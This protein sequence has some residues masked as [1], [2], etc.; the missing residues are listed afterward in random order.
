MNTTNIRV[1]RLVGPELAP[2][3]VGKPAKYL[4]VADLSTD[5]QLES[6]SQGGFVPNP[7]L[8]VLAQTAEARTYKFEE[9]SRNT[10]SFHDPLM[11]QLAVCGLLQTDGK[12]FGGS[13]RFAADVDGD[14]ASAISASAAAFPAAP[15]CFSQVAAATMAKDG[16]WPPKE[17]SGIETTSLSL[18]VGTVEVAIRNEG[19]DR[20]IWDYW[21]IGSKKLINGEHYL[22]ILGGAVY[23]KVVHGAFP[24]VVDQSITSKPKLKTYKDSAAVDRIVLTLTAGGVEFDALIDDPFGTAAQI[25]VRLRIAPDGA[26]EQHMVLLQERSGDKGLR[27]VL[28]DL[29]EAVRREQLPLV[30]DIRPGPA[31]LVW[32]LSR[33]EHRLTL[34]DGIKRPMIAPGALRATLVTEPV[35]GARLNTT[36]T[37]IK[38]GLMIDSTKPGAR[39]LVVEAGKQPSES[40]AVAAV[41]LVKLRGKNAFQVGFGGRKGTA[42]ATALPVLVERDRLAAELELRYQRQGLSPLDKPV[43][44]FA[45]VALERGV[46]QIPLPKIQAP[47]E[48]LTSGGLD[49]DNQAFFGLTFTRLL[50]Y[51]PQGSNAAPACVGDVI[52]DSASFVRT[53]V[54]FAG[55]IPMGCDITLLDANGVING[56]LWFSEATPTAQEVIPMLDNGP[57]ALRSTALSFGHTSTTNSDWTGSIEPVEPSQSVSALKLDLYVEAREYAPVVHWAPIVGMRMPLIAGMNMTRTAPNAAIPSRTRD[58]VP[59]FHEVPKGSKTATVTINLQAFSKSLPVASI[60]STS[61]QPSFGWPRIND[62]WITRQAERDDELKEAV[63]FSILTLPGVEVVPTTTNRADPVLE[64]SLR[65][66][67]PIL[68]ELFAEATFVRSQPIRDSLRP[69]PQITALDISALKEV[70]SAATHRLA[71]TRTEQ[72]RMTGWGTT[73]AKGLVEP[74]TWATGFKVEVTSPDTPSLPFGRY[75]LY[76]DAKGNFKWAKGESALAGLKEIFKETGGTLS[77]GDRYAVTGF[78]LTPYEYFIDGPGSAGKTGAVGDT[79][80]FVMAKVVQ[81]PQKYFG[82]SVRKTALRVS[83]DQ[84]SDTRIDLLTTTHQF[85][86][87]LHQIALE[88]WVRDLPMKPLVDDGWAFTAVDTPESAIG[89]D[90][91]VFDKTRLPKSV[92][93][94]RLFVNSKGNQPSAPLY[95]VSIGALTLHPLRLWSL[96]VDRHASL[97]LAN[98]LFSITPPHTFVRGNGKEPFGPEAPYET[99]N[100]VCIRFAMDSGKLQAIRI[101]NAGVNG[102]EIIVDESKNKATITLQLEAQ[103]KLG[104][105]LQSSMSCLVRVSFPIRIDGGKIAG[106]DESAELEMQLFGAPVTFSKGDVKIEETSIKIGFKGVGPTP[107]FLTIETINLEIS[108]TECL[109]TILGVATLGDLPTGNLREAI[110]VHLGGVI[111]WYGATISSGNNAKNLFNQVDH[112][113]GVLTVEL[114]GALCAG[115]WVRGIELSDTYARGFIVLVVQPSGEKGP[116]VW[117][118][119]TARFDVTAANAGAE[120]KIIQLTRIAQESTT[121]AIR[122]TLPLL[123]DRGNS[124]VEW[125]VGRLGDDALKFVNTT[126][127]YKGERKALYTVELVNNG[128]ALTHNVQPRLVDLSL[129]CSLLDR[130]NG[131]WLLKGVW[132]SKVFTEHTLNGD[133]RSMSFTTIDDVAIVDLANIAKR[134][135]NPIDTINKEYGFLPRYVYNKT[136]DGAP[137]IVAGIGRVGLFGRDIDRV[138]SMASMGGVEKSLAIFGGAVVEASLDKSDLSGVVFPLPWITSVFGGSLA[139]LIKIAQ[140]PALGMSASIGPVAA[141][142]LASA[143]ATPLEGLS[144]VLVSLGSGSG[145]EVRQTLSRVVG[146]E[147]AKVRNVVNQAFAANLFPN[148]DINAAFTQPLYWRSLMALARLWS[149]PNLERPTFKTLL[150]RPDQGDTVRVQVSLRI[151]DKQDTLKSGSDLLVVGRFHIGLMDVPEGSVKDD[152]DS[153]NHLTAFASTQVAEP[154]ALF[155]AT[156]SDPEWTDRAPEQ[157]NHADVRSIALTASF[158]LRR[159]CRL[160]DAERSIYASPA[161]GWPCPPQGDPYVLNVGEETV[162][163]DASHAWAGRARTIGGPAIGCAPKPA[164]GVADHADFLA[165]GRRALFSRGGKLAPNVVSPPDRALIPAGS[166]VRVPLGAEILS[167]LSKNLNAQGSTDS[168]YPPSLAALSPGR[169]EIFSSGV[170][171]GI[172]TMEYEGYLSVTKDLAFDPDHSRF[173]RPADRMPVIWRQGR[174]PRNTALPRGRTLTDSR[175]TYVGEN[176]YVDIKDIHTHAVS[177]ELLS[178]VLFC[179]PGAVLRYTPSAWDEKPDATIA[180]M[181]TVLAPDKGWLGHDLEEHVQIKVRRPK[182]IELKKDLAQT[183]AILG[184]AST[185]L[186]ATLQIGNVVA[187]FERLQ[188]AQLVDDYVT[189]SLVM[190]LGERDRLRAAVRSADADTRA[191]L[192]LRLASINPDALAPAPTD[193]LTIGQSEAEHSQ[194]PPGPPLTVTFGMLLLPADRPWRPIEVATIVFADPAYDRELAGPAHSTSKTGAGEKKYLLALDRAEYDLSQIIYFSFGEVNSG[195]LEPISKTPPLSIGDVWFITIELSPKAPVK[196]KATRPLTISGLPLAVP[197]QGNSGKAYAIPIAAL[198]EADGKPATLAPGDRLSISVRPLVPKDLPQDF[199]LS[200]DVGIVAFPVIAPPAAIYGVVT[201]DGQMATPVLFASAP[202]ASLIEFPDLIADLVR[203]HVRRRALFVWPFVPRTPILPGERKAGLVKI[204]RTG[205]GQ[206]PERPDVDFPPAE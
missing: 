121:T 132:Q 182:G 145:V 118:I 102:H 50:Q 86:L 60:T 82:L 69:L 94:W 173:G 96:Q 127:P 3:S 154:L 25:K 125:P 105:D 38:P 137:P 95:E 152:G 81:E 160:R 164:E 190:T 14:N 98:V 84:K 12:K 110:K 64:Y 18:T 172:L 75:A 47:A 166:R 180:L 91:T 67:L 61:T 16:V 28:D 146:C 76:G 62:E 162:I 129:D 65:Y 203:G 100:S 29:V 19:G 42:A 97:T 4:W 205:G 54:P 138:L 120:L 72:D 33:G 87:E 171:P 71:L 167:A 135:A 153:L 23:L 177:R 39:L 199:E 70:W 13:L 176:H 184:F 6:K 8:R 183:L 165:I 186:Y 143:I 49:E 197:A 55:D 122:V 119:T 196:G 43:E 1:V 26:G 131:D 148:P 174:A 93:E 157:R 52:V 185:G 101:G 99:G 179:G 114:R 41:N 15:I 107:G 133:G 108:S 46:L 103:L 113:R 35:T 130:V 115:Q 37:L 22:P 168:A 206:I 158:E 63:A 109:L 170:R 189:L 192:N 128:T 117:S 89:P 140:A 51:P 27:P 159:F 21:A 169:F 156:I 175:R 30:F 106:F 74:F 9:G 73:D 161:L 17:G 48:S 141:F 104:A 68:G 59:V 78:A 142:D 188:V 187:A 24:Y 56:A 40:L 2:A 66:D 123:V 58:L 193:W 77:Q 151:C 83:H 116:M 80:G 155:V 10:V 147:A 7:S 112:R 204:D 45:F 195:F 44:L 202:Q 85:D 34:R 124:V 57:I 90:V 181:L 5:L 36:A 79:R 198:A 178:F 201:H 139:P 200:I 191:L 144:P 149:V 111:D 163:Q 150:A 126:K 31:P 20:D 136:P 11:F 88:L 32:R 134:L 53:R 194:L 92:Y